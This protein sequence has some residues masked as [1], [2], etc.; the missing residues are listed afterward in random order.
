MARS[1]RGTA[2]YAQRLLDA[3]MKTPLRCAYR[4]KVELT[5]L[6]DLLGD[7]HESYPLPVQGMPYHH[8]LLNEDMECWTARFFCK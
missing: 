2:I 3:D 1:T 6:I 4:K 5:Y 8:Y 7:S